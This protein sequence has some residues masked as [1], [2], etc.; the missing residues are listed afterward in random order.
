VHH[1]PGKG[2]ELRE[3]EA[4]QTDRWMGDLLKP[5]AKM[6]GRGL[7]VMAGFQSSD[8][9]DLGWSFTGM[10]RSPGVSTWTVTVI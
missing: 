8:P 5:E 9:G 6:E 2:E 10:G 7:E 3:D 4:V 1:R